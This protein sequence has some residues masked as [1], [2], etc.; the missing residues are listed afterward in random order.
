MNRR[1]RLALAT[2][3][4]KR[5]LPLQ[6][7][8]TRPQAEREVAAKAAVTYGLGDAGRRAVLRALRESRP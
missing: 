6:Q 4:A 3:W 8:V 7:G 1:D 5:T 2:S